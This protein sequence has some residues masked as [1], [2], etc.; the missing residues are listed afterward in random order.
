MRQKVLSDE[1][2]TNLLKLSTLEKDTVE[3]IG[4]ALSSL[5][6]ALFPGNQIRQVLGSIEAGDEG[7]SDIGEF[8]LS[9]MNWLLDSKPSRSIGEFVEDVLEAATLTEPKR[10]DAKVVESL[11]ANL[12]SLLTFPDLLASQNATN[13]VLDHERVLTAARVLT[14]IRPVFSG[15]ATIHPVAGMVVHTLKIAYATTRGN[16]EFYVALDGQ[17]I[18]VLI[19]TLERAKQ[20]AAVLAKVL[21]TAQLRKL[22]AS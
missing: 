4:R 12:T 17:D 8:L 2:I 14:D 9:L 10:F 21:Q 7:A 15:N 22:E 13:L 3:D 16:D 1:G 5:P 20:K 11:R 6:I 19:E 18:D